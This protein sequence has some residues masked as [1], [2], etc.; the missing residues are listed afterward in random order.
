ME[1]KCDRC[2]SV[3]PWEYRKKGVLTEEF[4][5]PECYEQNKV[6]PECYEQNKARTVLCLVGSFVVIMVIIGCVFY[7]F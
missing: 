4:L 2:N 5:C 6:C 3:C 1:F 7:P